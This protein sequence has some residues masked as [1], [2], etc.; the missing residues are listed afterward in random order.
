M[1]SD[2]SIILDEKGA[3]RVVWRGETSGVMFD[4]FEL[5]KTQRGTGFFFAEDKRQADFYAGCGSQARA[6][7]LRGDR[8]LDLTEGLYRPDALSRT[9]AVVEML[10]EA[11]DDWTDRYSGEPADILALIETG[12]LYDY[13]GTGS[14]ERWHRLFQIAAGLGYDAVRILDATDGVVA[15]VWVVFEPGQIESATPPPEQRPRRMKM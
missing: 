6:F 3:P 12:S 9:M 4:R 2:A 8:V 1:S 5:A 13:E 14:G 10:R 11:F 15:P 7:H